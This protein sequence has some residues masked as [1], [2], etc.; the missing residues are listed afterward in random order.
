MIKGMSDVGINHEAVLDTYIAAYNECLKGRPRDMTIG[1]HLCRGNFKDGK[2]F[3]EGGYDRI[4][5]KLFN[6]IDVDCY[7]VRQHL[8]FSQHWAAD[9]YYSWS[10]T[11]SVQVPSSLLSS[12]RRTRRL[13]LDWFHR[14]FPSL[15]SSSTSKSRFMM[16]QTSSLQEPHLVPKR[17]LSTSKTAIKLNY[18]SGLTPPQNLH[19]PTVRF[20]IA[21]R[22]QSY[23]RGDRQ[24]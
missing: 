2:H 24:S 20:R 6:E 21:F 3:S 4:A 13:S 17:Q 9:P 8:D 23:R 5:A 10:T 22:R 7:Y 1:L 15:N 12:C 14:R 19:Q 16:P 11:L 18:S